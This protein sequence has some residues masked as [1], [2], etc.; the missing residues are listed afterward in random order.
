MPAALAVEFGRIRMPKADLPLLIYDE[1][2]ET[3]GFKPALTI[4]E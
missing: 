3:G 4:G 1:N 2:R